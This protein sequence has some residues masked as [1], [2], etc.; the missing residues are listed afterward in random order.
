MSKAQRRLLTI[1]LVVIGLVFTLIGAVGVVALAT[2]GAVDAIEYS[3]AGPCP[4]GVVADGCWSEIPAIVEATRF[5]RMTRGPDQW[6]VTISDRLGTQRFDVQQREVF[7]RLRGQEPVVA[8]FWNGRPILLH[9]GVEDLPSEATPGENLRVDLL[10][11][12]LLPAGL[13]LTAWALWSAR[14]PLSRAATG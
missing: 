14:R 7:N 10:L 3:R 11:A 4:T 8:R 6:E 1:R 12:V 5:R 13:M 9:V 2:G